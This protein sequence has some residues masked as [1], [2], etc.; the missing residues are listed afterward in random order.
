[1]DKELETI[2]EYKAYIEELKKF[3]SIT[4]NH[5]KENSEIHLNQLAAALKP[6]RLNLKD[7]I[8]YGDFSELPH[9]QIVTIAEILRDD[10]KQIFK[11]LQKFGVNTNKYVQ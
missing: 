11:T 1:M 6:E 2:E 8:E 10:L 4:Q 9:D 7:A 5:Q 3:H